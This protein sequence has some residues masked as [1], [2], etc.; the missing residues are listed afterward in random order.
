MA[1]V[2]IPGDLI[3]FHG[4][5][6]LPYPPLPSFLLLPF[7]AIAGGYTVNTVFIVVVMSCL[8]LY[9]LYQILLRLLVPKE[10]LTWIL[11]AFFCG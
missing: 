2:Q 7:V 9:L 5:Y 6:Y 3:Y 8:N 1:N 11:A 4:L 10:Y